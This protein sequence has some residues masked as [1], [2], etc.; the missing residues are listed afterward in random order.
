MISSFRQSI[1]SILLVPALIA[2]FFTGAAWIWLD[3]NAHVPALTSNS[4]A[5]W[6]V[7]RTGAEHSME[8]TLGFLT[9][10]VTI[11][12][13]GELLL[14]R[15][16]KRNLSLDI[17][18]LRMYLLFLPFQAI[19]LIFIF[20]LNGTLNM[21]IGLAATRIAWFARFIGL[22]SLLCM[23]L[24]ISGMT[25]RGLSYIFAMGNLAS[26]AI[27]ANLPLDMTQP[28]GNWLYR[29]SIGS[30]LA[31][32]CIALELIAVFSF[33]GTSSDRMDK[34]NYLLALFQLLLVAGNDLS[35]FSDTVLGMPGVVLMLSGL[36]GLTWRLRRVH[37]RL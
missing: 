11:G 12:I 10:Y 18:F 24:Y 35:Y 4:M 22:G 21:E 26:L 2:A 28:M 9:I 19:R 6:G 34:E 32:F 5:W 25:R 30:P 15:R 33:L 3:K 7:V 14:R 8:Q 37:Q 36:A 13:V 17:F 31:L 16:F 29:T 20:T 1:L 23:G 27:A